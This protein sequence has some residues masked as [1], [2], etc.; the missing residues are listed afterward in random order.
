MK[1]HIHNARTRSTLLALPALVTLIICAAPRP[2]LAFSDDS[3]G[4]MVV[5]GGQH[6]VIQ[7]S[8]EVT[9]DLVVISG[10][11]DVYGKVD[12]DAVA[13]GGKIYIAPQGHVN[14]SL[15]NV[16]GVID[17]ESST[18]QGHGARPPVMPTAPPATP[19]PEETQPAPSMPWFAGWPTFLFMDGILAFF[20]FLLFPARTASATEHLVDNPILAGMLGFFS[21]IIFVLVV[22]ALAITLVGIP[23]IPLALLATIGGYLIGKAAIAEFIGNRIY[24][25]SKSA[26]PR[27]VASVAVG[28]AI[29][30]VVTAF[31]G[32]VGIVLYFCLAALAIGIALYMLMRTAQAH[33]SRRL[34]DAGLGMNFPAPRAPSEVASPTDPTMPG[35][36]P[37]A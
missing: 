29:L 36:P 2:V 26:Q 19:A 13:L 24:D 27:P 8:Q 32:W 34:T 30:F 9:G 31:T 22:I 25:I 33:R 23:L 17:N 4:D 14:G 37:T 10:S 3:S 12:G 7:A 11:A 28:L 15:V 21:P 1:T 5:F 6:Q 18:P 20:A 35:P 16:G